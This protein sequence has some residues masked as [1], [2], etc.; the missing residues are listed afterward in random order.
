M[1]AKDPNGTRRR[2]VVVNDD[3]AIL[4]LYRAMLEELDYQPVTMVTYAIETERIRAAEPDAVILDLEVGVQASYGVD[5]ARQLREDA[6]LASIPIVLCTA[7]AD[8]LDGERR[9]LQAIGVPVLLKPFTF[10]EIDAALRA[11]SH[12]E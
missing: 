9:A 8:A 6:R 2:V 10:D 3:Q 12:P 5:M 1:T 4:D 7:N 11:S